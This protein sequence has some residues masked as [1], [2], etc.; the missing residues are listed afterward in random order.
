[1]LYLI[2]IRSKYF[3]ISL[4]LNQFPII[5]VRPWA[6]GIIRDQGTPKEG[7]TDWGLGDSVLSILAETPHCPR[8]TPKELFK[9]KVSQDSSALLYVLFQLIHF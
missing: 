8:P 6:N 5:A 9:E 1:M 2:F 3:V 4:A 7:S